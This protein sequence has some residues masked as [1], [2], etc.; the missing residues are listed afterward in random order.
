MANDPLNDDKARLRTRIRRELAGSSPAVAT[1]AGESIDARLRPSKAWS[2]ASEVAI[3]VS[4]PGEVDTRPLIRSAFEDGKSLLL[5]RTLGGGD[6]EFALTRDLGRLRR[7]RFGVLEPG[8]E[9][10]AFEPKGSTLLL[11]PGLAFDRRG[12]RLGQ[13]AGYYDRALAELR[14]DGRDSLCLGV[15]FSLQIV[16][17][18]PMAR[19]DEFL[20]G[21]VTEDELWWA[22]R[23]KRRG[24]D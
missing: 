5:P 22:S 6:L 15:A 10:P 9:C 17:G 18:V 3:F 16:E 1:R 2:E 11:V 12:G 24:D 23:G 4:L 7:G 13:G 21:W 20:D 19:F 8:P 14:R